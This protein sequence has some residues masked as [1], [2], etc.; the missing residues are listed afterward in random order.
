MLENLHTAKSFRR[1]PASSYDSTGGNA[2]SAVIPGG[3]DYTRSLRG[4]GIIRHF[5]MTLAAKTPG[6]YRDI[7]LMV[8]FD[9]GK[10]TKC[11]RSPTNHGLLACTE[12]GPRTTSTLLGAF[13]ERIDGLSSMYRLHPHDPIPFTRS[14]RVSIEHGHA[15]DSEAHYRAVA[16]RHGRNRRQDRI[17]R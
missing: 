3:G 12:P 1:M 5:W 4:S 14:L 6:V 9:G 16:F 15:D 7:E 10:G 11:L 2:D 8:Y 13:V 17:T